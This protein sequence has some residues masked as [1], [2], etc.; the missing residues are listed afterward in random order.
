MYI[1]VYTQDS[2]IY[3]TSKYRSQKSF[4][5]TSGDYQLPIQLPDRAPPELHNNLSEDDPKDVE[6]LSATLK[7]ALY[8]TVVELCID[9]ITGDHGKTISDIVVRIQFSR[10]EFNNGMSKQQYNVDV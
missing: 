6:N 5:K 1:Y 10:I 3:C 4:K 7:L 9:G 8:G 2:I